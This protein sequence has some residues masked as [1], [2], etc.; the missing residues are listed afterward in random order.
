MGESQSCWLIWQNRSKID[1]SIVVIQ[2]TKSNFPTT[3][4]TKKVSANNSNDE[5]QPEIAIWSP[6]PEILISLGLIDSIEI[7]TAIMRFSTMSI[8]EIKYFR[9][10]RP[11]CY[12]R[13]SIVVATQSF[14]SLSLNSL[15]SKTPELPWNFDAIYHSFRYISISGLDGCIAISGCRSLS[16]SFGDT[17][18][19]L[20]MVENRTVQLETNKFVVLL[21]KLVGAFLPPCATGVHKNRRL[22]GLTFNMTLSECYV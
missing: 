22:R 2:V 11:Y 3:T 5:Q 10:R 20:A 6:K 15:W 9:F 17:F 16:Q 14:G 21:L 8:A 1:L 18:F 19:E 13:L 4:T 7:P 12:F